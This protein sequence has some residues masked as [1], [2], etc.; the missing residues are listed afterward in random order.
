VKTVSVVLVELD[1][2]MKGPSTPERGKKIAELSNRLELPTPARFVK[3]SSVA[4]HAGLDDIISEW[5][6][7]AEG[8]DA[9]AD[10]LTEVLTP[11]VGPFDVVEALRAD[12]QAAISAANETLD[13]V[14]RLSGGTFYDSRAV[15]NASVAPLDF[16]TLWDQAMQDAGPLRPALEA[17]ALATVGT[18]G[19]WDLAEW[20][21]FACAFVPIRVLRSVVA[22]EAA[23]L[24][25]E[26]QREFI[27]KL[28]NWRG[29]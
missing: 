2:T 10:A 11:Y 7:P 24:G 29:S 1:A 20:V 16:E 23:R 19:N 18:R 28:G 26:R 14:V 4:D 21:V 27:E 15:R 12:V 5:L 22:G 3:V 6:V 17:H 13:V 25:V 9:L 8:A